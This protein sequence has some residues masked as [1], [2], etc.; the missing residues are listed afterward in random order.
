[1]LGSAHDGEVVVAG[2]L[3]TKMVKAAG[4]TWF[5]VVTVPPKLGRTGDPPQPWGG[6]EDSKEA[7]DNLLACGAFERVGKVVPR[8]GSPLQVAVAQTIQMP[9]EDRQARRRGDSRRVGGRGMTTD[10]RGD[11]DN[12]TDLRHLYNAQAEQRVLGA[13]FIDNRLFA[14][15]AEIISPEDFGNALHGRIF[16]M[17]GK[18]IRAG[19][20]ANPVTLKDIFDRDG[21]LANAGGAKYLAQL[22]G[23]GAGVLRV[24]DY[25]VI[26]R[27]W[28][29][30][31][32]LIRSCEDVIKDAGNSLDRPADLIYS[33]HSEAL[34]KL[35]D[36][37]A[38]NDIFEITDAAWDPD[39]L[40]PRP[41]IGPPYILRRHITLPHGP[42]G[43]GKSQLIASWVVAL[44]L[45]QQFGRLRPEKRYSVLLAN[46][47]DDR[48]EQE[49]RLSAALKFF[50]A[51]PK[52]LVG[53]LFRVTI[54]D[55]ADATMFEL[56]ERSAVRA[57]RTF[58]A[59]DRACRKIQPDV[60]A[61]DTL[62]AINAVPEN[63]NTLMRRVMAM[64]RNCA[65]QHDM[66]LIIAH[67][68]NKS[69]SDAED[70]DQ[71]NVRGA[72]DIPNAARFELAVKKMTAPEAEGFNLPAVDRASYFR[73]G[74]LG[75][76]VNYIAADESE[77]FER[78]THI[79][80]GQPVVACIPWTPP[81]SFDGID[82][83]VANQILDEIDAGLPNG[84]RYSDHNAARDRAAWK[85]V[86]KHMPGKP[87]KVCR[88]AISKWLK[89]GVLISKEYY[90]QGRHEDVRGLFVNLVKRPG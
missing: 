7:V 89:N 59:F 74:S 9:R 10:F 65:R 64:L 82:I 20:D 71:A 87:E 23:A 34:A 24:E 48:E 54:A 17:A 57:T 62:V 78:V 80:S 22:A 19:T 27:D 69:G 12:A 85:V 39:Q 70:R 3:A 56:D 75:S 60:S 30:R 47:E 40:P 67:H 46:F 90:H 88:T 37:H 6:A 73:L 84:D 45:G 51:S 11:N 53:H 13:V 33:E 21:T 31:R 52:D 2:R 43:S 86:A 77:W 61:L 72:G 26:I 63:D 83:A 44:C 5:D 32:E 8:I 50:G 1:M 35:V 25:C 29:L 4:A 16:A 15:V 41:W 79:I 55:T 42:G 66:A 76:K 38:Q 28:A 58:D 49:L 81:N 18:L 14:R 68:D 36:G